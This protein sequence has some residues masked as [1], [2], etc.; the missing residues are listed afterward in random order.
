MDSE[1]EDEDA[2]DSE[3]EKRESDGDGG[4]H[5]RV[6]ECGEEKLVEIPG[7]SAEA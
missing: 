4:G 1:N 7:T 2:L 6:D 5:E 3:S